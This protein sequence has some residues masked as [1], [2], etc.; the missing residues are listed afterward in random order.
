MTKPK[1][2]HINCSIMANNDA[3]SQL[4]AI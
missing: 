2:L 4:Y 1:S 3:N